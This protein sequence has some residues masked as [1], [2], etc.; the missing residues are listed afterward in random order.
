MSKT[1]AAPADLQE[2][3]Y[4][5]SSEATPISMQLRSRH[6]I[7]RPL[8]WFDAE[9]G[10]QRALRYVTNQNTIFE[11]EQQ[12]FFVLGSIVFE[13]GRLKAKPQEV[14]LKNFLDHHPDNVAN[15]GSVFYLFDP[16]AKAQ[17]DLKTELAGYEAVA[18]ILDMG[19]ED[20][21]A[22]GRIYFP[23]TVDT[24]TSGELKRDVIRKAKLDPKAFMELANDSDVK[25][26]NLV[27]RVTDYGLVKIKDDSVTVVWAANGKL[28]VK[29]PFSSD[30]VKTFASYLMT[31]EGLE[32]QKSFALKLK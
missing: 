14:A 19:I 12:E 27:N 15:G 3:I 28:I 13:D 7:H 9:K 5:L 22:V 6:T 30:P 10:Y 25:M 1:K 24:L 11:D 16:E 4:L 23:T 29:L 18:I 2:K 21:E 26:I 20:L 32:L 17:E 8:Q 31:D